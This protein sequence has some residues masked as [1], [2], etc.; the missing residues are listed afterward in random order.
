MPLTL[1]QAI[2]RV[3]K[4][5]GAYDLNVSTLGGGITNQNFLVETGGES[6]VLR[7]PGANTELLGIDRHHEYQ[8]NLAAGSLGIAPEVVYF[9]QPEG[10]LITRFIAGRPVPPDEMK[11]REFI[12]MVAGALKKIH[13][14]PDIPGEFWVPQIVANY[15][16]IAQRY[17][18]AFPANFDQLLHGLHAAET[19]L[20]SSSQPLKP[21]HND[22]LNENFLYDGNLRILDWEYAGMGDPYFDLANFSVNHDFSDPEDDQLIIAYFGSRSPYIWARLKVMRVL[23]DFREA[24]WGMVQ[25]GIS[26]LDFDFRGYA[27]KHFERLSH[28][29]K[30]PHWEQWIKEISKH[31]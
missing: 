19:A 11:Q 28:N 16:E 2:A 29:I 27:D 10:Y 4:W 5:D 3:P 17:G 23:S 12:G 7:I 14:M 22:L 9:I 21:C 25:V 30:D 1:K 24:M 6:Y 20:L 18:V 8:A 26:Q 15:S 13:A 31:V